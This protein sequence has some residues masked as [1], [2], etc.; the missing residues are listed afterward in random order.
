MRKIV[1][2][3]NLREDR[4]P[5]G[6]KWISSPIVY[7]IVQELPDWDI[8]SYT[9]KVFGLVK[10]PLEL[11]YEEML[12]MPAV[13]LVA[14]FHCVTRW[15]VKDIQWE[16]VPTK[17]I[18]ELAKPEEKAKF[19]MIHCLEG[20]TT[21]IPIEYLLEEDTIL[22]YRMNGQV[23]PRRHGYPLRLVLPKLYAWKSAKY[24]WGMEFMEK[25]KP[26]FWEQRGYNMRGDPWREERYW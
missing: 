18:L 5:P 2:S 14:D 7:D 26:G 21:N 19:V 20:Y 3:I 1:S 4:L 13:E 17:Y 9:F 8:K 16:G 6:Q 23:L 15:S 11:S 24:V 22:A 12:K 25:D 10:N